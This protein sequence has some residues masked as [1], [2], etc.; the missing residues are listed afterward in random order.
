MIRAGRFFAVVVDGG[1][2]IHDDTRGLV[3]TVYL[4]RA[5]RGALKQEA[6]AEVARLYHETRHYTGVT[7]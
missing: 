1:Y 3:R 6:S 7:Q 4:P 5:M 2:Q